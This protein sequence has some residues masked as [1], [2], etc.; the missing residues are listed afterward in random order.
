MA[1]AVGIVALA[2]SLRQQWRELVGEPSRTFTAARLGEPVLF[3]SR[4]VDDLTARPKILEGLGHL[5]GGLREES[6]QRFEPRR[7]REAFAFDPVE[8]FEQLIAADQTVGRVM[9]GHW[10][11]SSARTRSAAVSTAARTAGVKSSVSSSVSAGSQPTMNVSRGKVPIARA[12]ASA[13]AGTVRCMSILLSD[14]TSSTFRTHTVPGSGTSSDGV[15]DDQPIARRHELLRQP[16]T[17]GPHFDEPHIV[18]APR[19][20]A[21]RLEPAE[22]GDPE[23]VVTAQLVAEGSDEHLHHRSL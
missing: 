12:T 2:V 18:R 3:S 19:G 8:K 20:Q 1:L 13:R 6:G 16:Q 4:V 10:S 9:I 17:A 11:S 5:G 23:S 21:Q 14:G 22:Y 7:A 15:D